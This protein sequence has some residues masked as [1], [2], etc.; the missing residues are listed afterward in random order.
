MQS[1]FLSVVR[2]D[3]PL[4][5]FTCNAL[6]AFLLSCLYLCVPV[7]LHGDQGR[8]VP[9]SS[10][11]TQLRAVQTQVPGTKPGSPARTVCVLNRRA[12]PPPQPF[13]LVFFKKNHEKLGV[14]VQA[15]NPS[16][17]E[18][19]VG[20]PL[21]SKIAWSYIVSSRRP[22]LRIETVPQNT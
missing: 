21:S 1:A 13:M 22:G 3:P 6:M 10:S 17:Q 18:G 8:W 11:Y 9:W 20:G 15:L 2:P 19:E 16:T 4:W 14:V 5:F 7:D 12:A